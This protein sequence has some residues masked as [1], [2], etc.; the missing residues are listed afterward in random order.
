MKKV[1]RKPINRIFFMI[2]VIVRKTPLNAG[3]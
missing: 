2:I 1:K 3:M